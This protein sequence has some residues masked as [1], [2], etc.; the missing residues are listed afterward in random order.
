MD[1]VKARKQ[2]NAVM[3]TIPKSFNVTAGTALKPQLTNRGIFFEFVNQ[4]DFFNFDEE[5]LTDLVR[6]GY[7]GEK[8]IE[9]YKHAK[10]H[11]SQSMD[12]LIDEAEIET[13]SQPAMSREEFEKEIGL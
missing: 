13:R 7:E 9:Q 2:G 11:L 1:I 6:E 5:I 4:D 3:V 8:L 12:K 10:H